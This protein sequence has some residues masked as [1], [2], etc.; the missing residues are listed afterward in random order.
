MRLKVLL[1]SLLMLSLIGLFPALANAACGSNDTG[2]CDTVRIGCPFRIATVVAGDS[3]MVPIYLWNDEVLGS[4][5]LGFKFDG[6][7]LEIVKKTYSLAGSIIPEG[8]IENGMVKEAIYDTIP[9]QYLFG[10]IDMTGEEANRIPVNTTDKAKL[11]VTLNFKVRVEATRK[12]IV[13]DS[14]YYPPAGPFILSTQAGASL[15][16]QYVHC[17]EGDIILGDT[18]CGDADVSRDVNIVDVVY[19][20]NYIFRDGDPPQDIRGGD[21]DCDLRF[22]IADVVYLINYIFS[23]G[24]APCARCN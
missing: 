15:S 17:P 3:I 21:V 24:L 13:I 12:I 20:I 11:L 5:S 18:P 4:F 6:T 8:G 14:A 10:W 7:E 1:V 19:M 16:P 23:V 22:T 2:V 9:G